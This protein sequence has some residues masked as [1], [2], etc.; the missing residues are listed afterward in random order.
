MWRPQGVPHSRSNH[1][2]LANFLPH[3]FKTSRITAL[4]TTVHYNSGQNTVRTQTLCI[5][6]RQNK[7]FMHT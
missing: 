4:K 7:L 5:Y 1:R 3:L 2:V 6:Y